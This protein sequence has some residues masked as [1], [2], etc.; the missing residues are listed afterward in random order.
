MNGI[1]TVRQIVT[2]EGKMNLIKQAKRLTALR[3]VWLEEAE[4]ALTLID[5][6]PQELKELEATGSDV[7]SDKLCISFANQEA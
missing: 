6:L 5:Q 4:R 1:L 2:K 3:R 7:N